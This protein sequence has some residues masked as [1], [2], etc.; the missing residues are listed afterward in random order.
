MTLQKGDSGQHVFMLQAAL[1]QAGYPLPAYG[2]DG[3]FGRETQAAVRRAQ[4]Q[5]LMPLTGVA[6]QPLFDLL[7]IPH[8]SSVDLP[9]GPTRSTSTKRPLILAGFAI[10]AL[11]AAVFYNRR[12][13]WTS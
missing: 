4:E 11:V 7:D 12:P 5:F 1:Q 8:I 2:V 10:A 13:S 9:V 3:I 6:D